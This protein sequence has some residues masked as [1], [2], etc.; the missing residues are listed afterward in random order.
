M[1]TLFPIYI[2]LMTITNS[3]VICCLIILSC[4]TL[5]VIGVII[6]VWGVMEPTK[7]FWFNRGLLPVIFVPAS[8]QF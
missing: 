1:D 8:S 4:I 3:V 6:V 2:T 5:T 7:G